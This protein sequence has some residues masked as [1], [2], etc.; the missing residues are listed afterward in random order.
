MVN[1][2]EVL[3]QARDNMTVKRVF[4]DPIERDGVTVIP[5]AKISGGGGGGG[6]QDDEGSSGGGV[7]YGL[8][9]EPVGAYLIKEGELIWRPAVPPIDVTRI[10]VAGNIALI[11]LLFVIRSIFVSR[12]KS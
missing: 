1:V 8:K 6:G 9:A 12:K 5:V 3:N 7:G 11:A 2:E 4:G 10:V